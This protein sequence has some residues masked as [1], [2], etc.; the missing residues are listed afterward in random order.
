VTASQF[1]WNTTGPPI[2]PSAVTTIGGVTYTGVTC[3][4]TTPCAVIA[5]DQNLR[6]P[7]TAEW[8]TDVQHAITNNLTIDV[9][10]VGNHAFNMYSRNDANQPAFGFGWN[11]PIAASPFNGLSPAALCVSNSTFSNCL[12]NKTITA[13]VTANEV[14]G[15][16]YSQFPYLNYITLEKNEWHSSYNGLQISVRERASHGL[17]FLASYTH[18]RA[19]DFSNGGGWAGPYSQDAYDVSHDY[20]PGG[21]D[22]KNRFTFQTSYNL[23]GRKSPG[24]LLEGWTVNGVV[25]LQGGIPWYPQDTTSDIQGTG[26]YADSNSAAAQYWNYSGPA[27]AFTSHPSNIPCFGN[28]AGCTPYVSNTPPQACVTAA[29]APYN[30]NAQLQ[31]LALTALTNLGCYV[32]GAGIL[33]PPAY[34]TFGNAFRGI[35]HAPP[36]YNVD[37]S[38]FKDWRFRERLTAQFRAEVFNLFN[39]VDVAVPN[40]IDPE[41]GL[42]FG[43]SCQTIDAAGGDTVFGAGGARTIQLGLKFIF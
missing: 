4:T 22:V 41:K 43:C 20:G 39:R 6:I 38:V 10:Y 14:A 7:F 13:A 24:Q 36:F 32:Q 19:L 15:R 33:T 28:L 31:A 8:N 9:A 17:T 34:G 30:G 5:L 21:L 37:F 25:L 12:A 35:F 2:F 1:N 3:T 23:P 16:P 29:E 40:V 18:D 42:G 26:E 11:N 27:A